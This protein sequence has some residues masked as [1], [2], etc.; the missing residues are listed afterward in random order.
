MRRA[1]L[2]G[3]VIVGSCWAGHAQQWVPPRPGQDMCDGW[4][5]AAH[6]AACAS[7][8]AEDRARDDQ[9]Q[10]AQ[11]AQVKA[12]QDAEAA[13][14]EAARKAT[15][16]R[17]RAAVAE[18]KAQRELWDE[19][20]AKMRADDEVR[21]EAFVR[22]EAADEFKRKDVLDTFVAPEAYVGQ[23]IKLG[24]M[25][26]YA[27]RDNDVRCWT[28]E[29]EVVVF[30]DDIQPLDAQTD[31]RDHC[32]S[33]RASSTTACLRVLRFEMGDFVRDTTEEGTPRVVIRPGVL[34]VAR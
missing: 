21:H 31:L 14:V 33:V 29:A 8:E 26:C 18:A 32:S 6:R 20:Q 30:A 24:G 3:V 4:R 27:P 9:R 5:D 7:G 2:A 16:D 1:M 34:H 17:E 13:R 23:K 19:Q 15:E 12:I 10:R 28:P 11:Q 22:A 25:F